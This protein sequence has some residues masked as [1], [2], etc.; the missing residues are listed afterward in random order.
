MTTL[1]TYVDCD[2]GKTYLI[3]TIEYKGEF[4]LVPKWLATTFP[5]VR[6]P[7]RMIR[8]PSDRVRD[9]GH[10][11]LGSGIRARKLDGLLPKA[12]LDVEIQL[13]PNQPLD[14]LEAPEIEVRS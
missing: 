10:D 3:D 4:W 1:K 9:L 6:K 7:A 14:V 11:F 8:L 5:S 13:Q 2:D 12:L